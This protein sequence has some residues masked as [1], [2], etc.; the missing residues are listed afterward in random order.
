MP[1]NHDYVAAIRAKWIDEYRDGARCG[2]DLKIN[3][4]REIGGYPKGF[5]EWLLERRNAWLA[6]FNM[7][8]SERARN[9]R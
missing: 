2:A 1:S 3:G 6:G 9:G 7:G 5:H 8:Y 4:P